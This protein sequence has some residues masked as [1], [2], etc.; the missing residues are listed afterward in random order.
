MKTVAQ[1]SQELVLRPQVA[2]QNLWSNRRLE[3]LRRREEGQSSIEYLGIIVV[4]ALIVVA[5]TAAAPKWGTQIV[6]GIGDQIDK[7]LK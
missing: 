4:V 6:N 1:R 5:L 3:A 7:I 2:L